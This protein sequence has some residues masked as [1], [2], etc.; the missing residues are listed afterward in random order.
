MIY[1]HEVD[2]VDPRT[3]YGGLFHALSLALLRAHGNS[4]AL[5]RPKS[6]PEKLA[7]DVEIFFGQPY[8]AVEKQFAERR[9]PLK[10]VYTMFER[11]EIPWEFVYCVEKYFDFVIVPTEWCAGVFRRVFPNHPIYVSPAGVDGYLYPYMERPSDRNPFT[12]LWQGFHMNDRKRFDLVLEAFRLLNLPDAW[13]LLKIFAKASL[14]QAVYYLH[15][16]NE[17]VSFIGDCC[18][19][20]EKL[21]LWHQCDFA[22]CPSNS[23]G[24]GM[25]PL[26]WMASGL[27]CAFT[28]NTGAANFANSDFNYPLPAT[29][30]GVDKDGLEYSGPSINSVAAV[31]LHAY[32]NRIEIKEK[33]SAA[34]RWVRF[35][36]GIDGAAD[37]FV[38]TVERIQAD[39]KGAPQCLATMSA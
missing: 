26:E 38:R 18:S 24:I 8:K 32:N 5:F 6:L 36:Y 21:S 20:A 10:G 12:F 16:K 19:H 13:L 37:E 39:M 1:L 22:I 17:R 28:N 11:T 7:P 29:E 4:V 27:P 2:S 30:I 34:A 23:E 33:A 3:G 9:A 15:D 25:M 14:S 31:M 35:N